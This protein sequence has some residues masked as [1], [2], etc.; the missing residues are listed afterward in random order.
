TRRA[1]DYAGPFE[2]LH[3]WMP[4]VPQ[5]KDVSPEAC[6]WIEAAP[7]VPREY[8]GPPRVIT[9]LTPPNII[10]SLDT[11]RLS[12]I[13]DCALGLGDPAENFANLVLCRGPSFLRRALDAYELPVDAGLIDRAIFL[14]RTEAM[15]WLLGATKAG[16]PFGMLR[17][18]GG[19]FDDG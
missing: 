6:A 7:A 16:D 1:T 10:V 5:I 19:A 8:C 14:G 3:R 12:G 15:A 18:V 11:G 2:E 9:D 13:I 17:V 4:L